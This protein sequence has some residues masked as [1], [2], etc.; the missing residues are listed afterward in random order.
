MRFRLSI[1]AAV[2]AALAAEADVRFAAAHEFPD[3]GLKLPLPVGAEADPLDLPRASG[4]LV[5]STGGV[6]RLE[7]RFDAFDLWTSLAVRGRWRD[8][9]GNRFVLARLSARPP[10]DPAGA[11]PVTRTAFRD[12]LRRLDPKRPEQ[13][14]EAVVACSPVDVGRPERP[15]RAQRRNFEEILRYPVAATDVCAV[16]CAFRPRLADRRLKPDW[17]LAALVLAAGED[18]AAAEAAFDAKFLDAVEGLG[19]YA[20]DEVWR[21]GGEGAPRPPLSEEELLRRDFRRNV[22]N[23][24]NWHFAA[25]EGVVVADDLQSPERA[26]FVAALTNGLPRLRR[27]YARLVPSP[28]AGEAHTA[29]VRV[30]GTRAEYLACVGEANAWTAAVWCPSRRELVLHLPESG[31]DEL[32]RTVWHEAFHQHLDYAAAFGTASPWFNEG[33]AELFEHVHFDADGEVVFDLDENA[34]AFVREHADTLVEALPG[35]LFIDYGDFYAEDPALCRMNY[36]LAWSI[37]YFLQVGAPEVRF[38]PFA[39]LRADYVKN[40]LAGRNRVKAT[41]AVLPPDLLEDLVAEWRKFWRD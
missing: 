26:A 35:F 28:L 11:P 5:S 30:F 32:L 22:A 20:E 15:R 16:V 14:D 9:A 1:T 17:Y 31:A 29:L 3:F 4:F 24:G 33:H 8:A 36:R 13:L 7:D 18:P 34:A 39:N 27:A 10:E 40:L 12:A 23:Y 2:F 41:A 19:A 6:S 38:R 21:D 25:A 37:A